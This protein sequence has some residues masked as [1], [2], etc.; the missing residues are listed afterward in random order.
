MK[1]FTPLDRTFVLLDRTF[2][3]SAFT[4]AGIAL[5]SL[6]GCDS[7]GSFRP[8]APAPIVQAQPPATNAT[9]ELMKRMLDRFDQMEK[10]KSAAELAEQTAKAQAAVSNASQAVTEAQSA[11][12]NSNAN[13][14]AQQP[15]DQNLANF[16][17]PFNPPH[18]PPAEEIDRPSDG[19]SGFTDDSNRR[20]TFGEIQA[21]RE[22]IAE[23]KESKESAKKTEETLVQLESKVAARVDQSV[24]SAMWDR[25]YG[26]FTL[27]DGR[28]F[29]NYT[30]AIVLTGDDCPYCDLLVDCIR[31]KGVTSNWTIGN[32]A[33]YH[34]WLIRGTDKWRELQGFPYIVYL[35]NGRKIDEHAGFKSQDLDE[36]LWR[37]PRTK[38]SRERLARQTGKQYQQIGK[39]YIKLVNDDFFE[40]RYSYPLYSSSVGCSA[41]SQSYSYSYSPPTYRYA[42]PPVVTYSAPPVYSSG[43]STPQS[44]S[45]QSYYQPRSYS[46]GYPSYPSRSWSGGFSAGFS[47]GGGGGRYCDP[48]TGVCY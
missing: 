4:L 16:S 28:D 1:S 5:L 19:F 12:R 3:F 27:D 32:S 30:G 18:A 24:K 43:C 25:S 31:S 23:L 13:A 29:G 15:I 7:R 47:G 26:R 8:Q 6:T 14:P 46:Y 42:S 48:Y 36:I 40:T 17:S 44:Y 34:F 35:E 20:S 11:V 21:L 2:I 33:S 41:P 38:E 39:S 37:H 9:E 10:D 45:Y 22:E